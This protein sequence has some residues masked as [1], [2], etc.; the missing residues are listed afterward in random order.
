MAAGPT[1]PSGSSAAQHPLCASRRTTGALRTWAVRFTDYVAT[2]RAMGDAVRSAVASDSSFFAETKQRISG[3]LRLLLEAGAASGAL[4]PDSDP[5]DVM[6]VM[7]AIW[8]LPD[9]PDW[10]RDVGR[11]LDLVIDGLRYRASEDS[12]TRR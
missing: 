5:D 12:P 3:A 1:N 7:S 10:R 2:K 4:R 9:G 8:F 6:R 11:M